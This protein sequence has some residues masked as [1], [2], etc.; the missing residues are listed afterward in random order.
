MVQNTRRLTGVPTICIDLDT[1]E[2]FIEILE[3]INT[4]A[5]TSKQEK[6]EKFLSTIASKIAEKSDLAVSIQEVNIL[7]EQLLSL[8]DPFT[9]DFDK[10]IAIKMTKYDIERKFSRK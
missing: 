8:R 10:P 9:Y 2:L 5:R 1:K 6:E 3:E 4:V 7:M